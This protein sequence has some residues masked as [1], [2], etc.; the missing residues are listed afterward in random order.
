MGIIAAEASAQ[1]KKSTTPPPVQLTEAEKNFEK[2]VIALEKHLSANKPC[3]PSPSKAPPEINGSGPSA[4][5]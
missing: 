4:R 3:I 1:E 2:H 5:G